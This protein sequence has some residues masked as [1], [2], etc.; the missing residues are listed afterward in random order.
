M[1]DKESF[2][3]M[4]KPVGSRCNMRCS[5]CYYLDKGKY[6]MHKKQSCMKTA[7]LERIIRETI[8]AQKGDVISFVWHGGEPLL[9]GIPFY[10]KALELQKKYLPAGK[11]VWNN[12]QTNG[13]ML[14]DE[15]CR[16]LAMNHFDVG[17][18]I[19]G[20]EAVH[21]QNRRDL[22]GSATWQRITDNIRRLKK[23]RIMPDLLCTVNSETVKDPLGVYHCLK[24][25][26]TGWIQFIP[27]VI[28]RN[29]GT[30][31]SLSVKPEEYGEFLCRIF[32]EWITT[33]LGKTDVQLFV[34]AARTAAGGKPSVCWLSE[35]CG[36]VLIAEEDGS[37][38]A[39]DH[40]VD[41]LH[42]RGNIQNTKLNKM[43]YSDAQKEFGESKR[44]A[45][46]RQCL[47]CQ[48]LKYCR[49]GCLKD[50]FKDDSSGEEQYYLCRGM[51]MFYQHSV[52]FLEKATELS[53]K[54]YTSAQIMDEIKGA[55]TNR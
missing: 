24:E 27:I 52:S 54:K 40:F 3:M 16:F 35:T 20:T 53:A 10:Q 33:D 47:E 48:W 18:S 21:N 15:W 55:V 11:T 31:S 5:Y 6:S 36:K 51:K 43:V 13:L 22:N 50:R 17:I 8:Q 19:D 37:I 46:S 41:D 23:Y 1:I 2:V 25:L 32:D 29:D 9:A 39:C 49:G 14:N 44:T 38:Y 28:R 7:L 12:I 42:R 45:L 26:D 34:E 4:V 30:F